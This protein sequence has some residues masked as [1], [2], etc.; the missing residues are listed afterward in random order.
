MQYPLW[1]MMHGSHC[2][3][4]PTEIFLNYKRKLRKYVNI[5]KHNQENTLKCRCVNKNHD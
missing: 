1:F 3:R 2:L 4:V 5:T